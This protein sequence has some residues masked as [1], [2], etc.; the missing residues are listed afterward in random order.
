LGGTDRAYRIVIARELA[1]CRDDRHGT[2][3]LLAS[4]RVAGRN[5]ERH[6]PAL[7]T[8]DCRDS[9]LPRTHSDRLLALAQR[10][11]RVGV[12]IR[13][14]GPRYKARDQAASARPLSCDGTPLPSCEPRSEDGSDVVGIVEATG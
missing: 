5:S 12:V 2:E 7:T 8:G 13:T 6:E 9:Q 3:P 14:F 11:R 10:T 4:D 1:A